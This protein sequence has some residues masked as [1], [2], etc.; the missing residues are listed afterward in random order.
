MRL[1]RSH[2]MTI[3][4]VQAMVVAEAGIIGAVGG[5][6]AVGI[7]ALVAW[8]TVTIAA[9][10]APRGLPR[11]RHPQRPRVAGSSMRERLRIARPERIVSDEADAGSFRIGMKVHQNNDFAAAAA[12]ITSGAG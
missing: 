3:G 6:A 5:I 4:Q 10:A 8:V 2:G 11:R 1:L 7:G 9:P 12:A